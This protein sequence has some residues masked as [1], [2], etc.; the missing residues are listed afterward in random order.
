MVNARYCGQSTSNQ[1]P[2]RKIF[3]MMTRKNLNGLRY[4]IHCTG[5]G[6]LAMGNTNPLSI[7]NGT[8]KKKAVIMACCLVEEMVEMKSP[9]P[10]VLNKNKQAAS[11]S[12]RKLPLKGI[13][14]Q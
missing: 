12:S 1:T 6:I 8:T 14:N 13:S 10:S 5:S 9:M 4:V 2:F 3:L 7:K 11:K